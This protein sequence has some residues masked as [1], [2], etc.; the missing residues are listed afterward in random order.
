M[1]QS[2]KLITILK[3]KQ[4][5]LAVFTPAKLDIISSASD[6]RASLD[7]TFAQTRAYEWGG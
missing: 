7:F 1:L 6:Y 5:R 3:W 2:L 4:C